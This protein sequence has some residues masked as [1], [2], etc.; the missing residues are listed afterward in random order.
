MNLARKMII[1][2]IKRKL[3]GAMEQP[4]EELKNA[5]LKALAI[6]E[7]MISLVFQS[8]IRN[9]S[10]ADHAWSIFLKFYVKRSLHNRV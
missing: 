5:D 1:Y 2:H 8:M 6:I 10:S 7:R 4:T 9:A 3:E